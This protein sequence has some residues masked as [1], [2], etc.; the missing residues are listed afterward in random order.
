M[1]YFHRELFDFGFILPFVG[2]V[3]VLREN[4][5]NQILVEA[6]EQT[7]QALNFLFAAGDLLVQLCPFG[8]LLGQLQ[9]GKRVAAQGRI[10]SILEHISK[11]IQKN[12][13]PNQDTGAA[14]FC[15][16]AVG[17]AVKE[18]DISGLFAEVPMP[19]ETAAAVGTE[20]FSL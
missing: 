16:S 8:C 11:G 7:S 17:Q 6:A 12:I 1:G 10:Q 9:K 14:L 3:F 5:L 18:V 15:D 19:V 2:D 20:D 13:L 4:I